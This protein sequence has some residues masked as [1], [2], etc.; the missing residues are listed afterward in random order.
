MPPLDD[1]SVSGLR[2]KL[3]N[4]MSP[5]KSGADEYLG[6]ALRLH[7]CIADRHW[8]GKAIVGPDPIGK[9]NWRV[10]RF[11][12]GY[13]GWLPWGDNW[14]YLQGQS[15]WIKA[16]LKLFELTDDTHYLDIASRC[17][18]YMVSTQPANGAWEHPP[19]RERRGFIA[20][21]ENVWACLGLVAAYRIVDK[22]EYLNSAL[23]CYSF[24]TN[25]TGFGRLK[26]GLAINYHVHTSD[27]VPNATTMFLWLA[28]ELQE[29]TGDKRYH[30]YVEAM[31]R[32]LEYSQLA[33]GELQYR[34][35]KRPHFQCYQYNSFQFLDLV[36]Y[37]ALTK[38]ERVWD[39]MAKIARFLS[40]GVT[41]RGSCRY[42]CF[43]ENPETNYWT[44][45]LASALRQ[46]HR[47]GLGSYLDLSERAYRR[48]LSRQNANGSFHFSSKNYRLLTDRRS[49]PRQEAMILY[50]LLSRVDNMRPT[51]RLG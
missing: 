21:V 6:A 11:I 48:L 20:T 7:D 2:L 26:D 1:L 27:L 14:T 28:S 29:V 45:A 15:Y 34:Y 47:L 46:A 13:A 23:K 35:G 19:L 33:S 10:T 12:K 38:N 32:F 50:F 40:S 16:N 49:Y 30:D 25:V 18:D 31:I 24:L 17:A 3:F 39:I 5:G 36:N 51:L 41:R 43:K 8:N 22:P 4:S 9:I 42:D 44:V 37:Y